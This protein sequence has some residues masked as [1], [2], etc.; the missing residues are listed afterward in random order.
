MRGENKQTIPIN[1]KSW[2]EAALQLHCSADI[3]MM[4]SGQSASRGQNRFQVKQN[5]EKF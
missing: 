2:L 3:A 1:I 5:Y 4:S